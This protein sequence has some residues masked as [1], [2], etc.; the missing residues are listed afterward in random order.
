MTLT[1]NR[2]TILLL[3]AAAQIALTALFVW[4]LV[5]SIE[6]DLRARSERALS[7]RNL[8]WASLEIDG[9]D[10]VI[11]GLAPN[12]KHHEWALDALAEVEGL[13]RIEDRITGIG[14]DT[15][16]RAP[17]AV[18]ASEPV[19]DET[20]LAAELDREIDLSRAGLSYEFRLERDRDLVRITGMA[21]D[22]NSKETL[23]GLAREKFGG[24]QIIDQLKVVKDAPPGFLFAATQALNIAQLLADGA[25]GVR[26]NQVYVEG[27]TGND[28]DLARVRDLINNALPDGYTSSLQMSSRQSVDAVLRENPNLAERIGPL[29]GAANDSGTI[30][31][32]SATRLD[33]SPAA[34][35]HCQDAF[36]AA[37][38][39]EKIAFDTGSSDISEA[40]S[41]L[42]S[43]LVEIAKSCPSATIEIGGHT[44]DQGRESNNLALSQRRAEA[45]M[46]YFVTNGVKLGRLR[47]V[48]Y[49]ESRPL[50]ENRTLTDRARNRRIEFKI[51]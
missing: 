20:A 51:N 40:S 11:S 28:R 23:V 46:E 8:H 31:L 17:V 43:K 38:G 16:T 30:S 26:G 12:Q 25:T 18:I 22:E 41:A 10:I 47:A 3:G 37:L 35:K 19:P 39:E 36:D 34:A 9:R 21:P 32:G 42:L 7:N 48:G 1:L 33:R 6:D 44:D 5:P 50:V 27:L 15:L 45:V 49:G 4:R 24:N 29:P 14:A 13:R 2:G